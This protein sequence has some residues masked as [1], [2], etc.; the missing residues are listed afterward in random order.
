MSGEGPYFLQ[1]SLLTKLFIMIFADKCPNFIVHAR[2]EKAIID[3]VGAF[4]G[5]DTVKLLEVPLTAL[6]P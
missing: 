4:S 1:G 5:L 6:S 2:P 3:N